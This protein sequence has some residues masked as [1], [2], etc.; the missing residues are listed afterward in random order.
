MGTIILVQCRESK[1]GRHRKL[2]DI[3]LGFA[4]IINIVEKRLMGIE[5]SI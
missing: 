2:L 1:T 4:C 3:W 5:T